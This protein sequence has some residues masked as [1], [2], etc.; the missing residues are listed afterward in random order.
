M[1]DSKDG[2]RRNQETDVDIQFAC[3]RCGQ[4]IAVDET[5]AGLT[6]QC[7]T[8][9]HNLVVPAPPAKAINNPP[10]PPLPPPVPVV[11]KEIQT[12]VKQGALIGG[13][14]CFMVAAMFLILPIPTF[15]LWIPLVLAAFI[16]SIVAMSQRRVAGGLALLLA[17][18]IGVPILWV[19]G[20]QGFI[21]NVTEGLTT[22][23]Q[24]SSPSLKSAAE[25]PVT[26]KASMPAEQNTSTQEP[27]A[28]DV[29]A[30]FREYK[31]GEKISDITG[32]LKKTYDYSDDTESYEVDS[33]DHSLGNFQ[34]SSIVLRF[35]KTLGLLKEVTIHVRG[36]ENSDGLLETLRTAY[37]QPQLGGFVISTYKWN[38]VDIALHYEKSPTG[39]SAWASW[40]S[41]KVDRLIDSERERRVK[42]G[43]VDAAKG[44]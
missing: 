37:G 24:A 32:G 39:G 6:V 16:L 10:P 3:A 1:L 15:F 22:S 36:D 30:G 21:R 12:N 38:G 28:L 17:T 31:L 18:V 7:P 2:V 4:H 5:G 8:C 27:T 23:G 25:S 34:I 44:L 29:K 14:V 9:S 42:E 11:Q 43:A 41:K 19:L 40:T 33:F 13:W 35:D 26:D 20:T